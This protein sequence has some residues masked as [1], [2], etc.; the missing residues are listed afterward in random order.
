MNRYGRRS[1]PGNITVYRIDV[2][3]MRLTLR[4]KISDRF[5]F[6]SCQIEIQNVKKIWGVHRT[7]VLLLGRFI[8]SFIFH[9]V[10]SPPVM[11]LFLQSR[12]PEPT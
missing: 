3:V 12:N 11:P 1:L 6:R 9:L 8:L 10:F 4:T 5:H 2:F 7:R